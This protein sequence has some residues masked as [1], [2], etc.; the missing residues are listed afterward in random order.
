MRKVVAVSFLAV[1]LSMAG[2]VGSGGANDE[3]GTAMTPV[4]GSLGGGVPSGELLE[5]AGVAGAGSNEGLLRLL[6]GVCTGADRAAVSLPTPLGVF[7]LC[8][9]GAER[10]VQK[11]CCQLGGTLRQYWELQRCVGGT[12]IA[13]A[14]ACTGLCSYCCP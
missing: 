13:Y 3:P 8:R 4:P 7:S 1:A 12:W 10:K 9:E 14:A 11:G 6:L 2:A 5:S